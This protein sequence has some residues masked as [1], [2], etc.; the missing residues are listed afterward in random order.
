MYAYD[1]LSLCV[2]GGLPR[3][4][5]G[6]SAAFVQQTCVIHDSDRDIP[7]DD[8]YN[9]YFIPKGTIVIANAW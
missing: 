2:I 1:M 5:Y 6:V 9:G 8:W 7:Q 4:T 3:R